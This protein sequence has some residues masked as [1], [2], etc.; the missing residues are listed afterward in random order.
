MPPKQEMYTFKQIKEILETNEET[1]LKFFNATVD[2]LERKIDLLNDENKD[3]KREIVDIKKS[4]DFNDER[5]DSTTKELEDWKK[6]IKTRP[7]QTT[8]KLEDKLAEMEDRSRRNNLR[9][10]GIPE[11]LRMKSGKHRKKRLSK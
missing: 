1:M 11:I 4:I 9:F 7:H 2:R 5:L 3:L 8:E 6:N 10:D